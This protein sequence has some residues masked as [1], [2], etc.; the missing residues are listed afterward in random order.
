MGCTQQK[1]THDNNTRKITNALN[2]NNNAAIQ[3][4][5]HNNINELNNALSND[6]N[7]LII[8]KSESDTG[9]TSKNNKYI[10]YVKK[11]KNT[12]NKSQK[13]WSMYSLKMP[14]NKIKKMQSPTTWGSIIWRVGFPTLR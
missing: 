14:K 2:Y 13:S 11:E 12:N 3:I 5:E 6:I 4:L 8:V 9:N 1:Q 7:E 10:V